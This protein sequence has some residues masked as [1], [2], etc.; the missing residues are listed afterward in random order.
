MGVG[1]IS[2]FSGVNAYLFSA[3][4]KRHNLVGVIDSKLSGFWKGTREISPTWNDTV[5]LSKY[6]NDQVQINVVPNPNNGIFN[7][8]INL[9]I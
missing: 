2:G 3:L 7:L 1:G 9:S 4:A 8:N 5:G 6:E